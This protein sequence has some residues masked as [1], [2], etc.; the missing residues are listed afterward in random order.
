MAAGA[1]MADPRLDE[2]V[3]SPY[4]ENHV[5]EL[6]TRWGQE[7]GPGELKGA[8]TSVVEVEYGLNDRISL[9][10]LGQVEREPGGGDRLVGTGLESVI[11]L[12]QI[13]KLGVDA[14]GYLEYKAGL[15]G[16][17][18]EGEAKLL[19]AKT[20][21][22]FQG[23]FNFI[24]ERPFGAPQGDDYASYGY[25][26]SATWQTFGAMRLGVQAFGDMGD[27]HGL[28]KTPQGAYVGPQVK[29]EGRPANVPFDIA[30]DAGWLAAVG[31]AKREAGNQAKIA[32]EFERRF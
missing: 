22:R 16:E 4:V 14:G 1:A 5:L 7:F 8:R 20:A 11:Y 23:L 19:L 17:P 6:E 13:P 32:L 31:A 12:G 15:H 29:W 24:V 9:A 21:G 18:D 3:Y 10:V 30:L 27:D 26:A 28:F 2:K 25:A